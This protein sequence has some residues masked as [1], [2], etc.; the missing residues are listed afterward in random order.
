MCTCPATPV[1][2]TSGEPGDCEN[3]SEY[4]KANLKL[5]ELRNG[6]KL[7]THAAGNYIRNELATALRKVG[8][9]RCT[10]PPCAVV[11]H[12]PGGAVKPPPEPQL[13]PPRARPSPFHR[14]RTR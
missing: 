12:Q 1:Q 7:T 5:Y 9:V 8:T 4:V 2:S 10:R 11:V 6:A 3:F 13:T 14:T